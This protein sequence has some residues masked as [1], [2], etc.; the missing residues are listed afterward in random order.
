METQKRE[1]NYI[2]GRYKNT[3]EC[4]N[5]KYNHVVNVVRFEYGRRR[6]NPT[7]GTVCLK[8]KEAD[9]GKR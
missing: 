9:N 1:C 3:I 6:G 7:A 8:E 4:A 2:A 5:C